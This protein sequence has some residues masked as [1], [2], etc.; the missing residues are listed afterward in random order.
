MKTETKVFSLVAGGLAAAAVFGFLIWLFSLE[1]TRGL[2]AWGWRRIFL[3]V[4]VVGALPLLLALAGLP[5]LR[6]EEA[7]PGALFSG[8][9]IG[10]AAL[11]IVAVAIGFGEIELRARR[12]T[13]PR[14]TLKLIE[15]AAG[16]IPGGPADPESGAMLRLSISSDPHWGAETANAT[17]RTA[18]LGAIA[19][20][21]P[22]RDAFFILGDN[23]DFGLNEAAWR[24]EAL[25]LAAALPDI[26]IRPLLGNH[27]ALL[28]GER[29]FA[30][31]FFPKRFRSDSGS[32]YYY[33][34]EAGPATII[35]L[36]LLWGTESF[37]ANQRAWL[38]R[39]LAAT[40]RERPVIVLSHCFFA[41]SGYVDEKTGLPWYDHADTLG[42]VAP[43]LERYGVDLVVSGHNHYMELLERNGLTYALVGAMGGTPDPV[44]S[45]SSPH[46]RWFSRAVYGW[47]DLDVSAKGIA[48][49][50]RDETGKLLHAAFVPAKR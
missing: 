43:I 10:L 20:A 35:V 47:L 45:Y 26:P 6:R 28:H 18:I 40:A 25:E 48:L 41:S 9:A 22:Q 30:S 17:A 36:N 8:T 19:A 32:P 5:W 4:A 23:V 50:F 1:G 33:A 15:P 21:Q 13:K 37:D 24:A 44:P 38:E 3:A 16:I 49:A 39:R 11:C 7:I 42:S 34:I 2:A 29:H 14:P 31:Y 27:D 12:L 46:S